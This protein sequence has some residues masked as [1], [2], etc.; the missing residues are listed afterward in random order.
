MTDSYHSIDIPQQLP[1]HPWY[2]NSFVIS[3]T[4]TTREWQRTFPW[5][6][7]HLSAPHLR[8]LFQWY[9][10]V[11][12]LVGLQRKAVG[13]GGKSGEKIIRSEHMEEVEK[14]MPVKQQFIDVISL[15]NLRPARQHHW[16]IPR[17]VG[18]R[19]PSQT[20][21]LLPRRCKHNFGMGSKIDLT[22][23]SPP[24]HPLHLHGFELHKPPPPR[25]PHA[26]KWFFPRRQVIH[27][28]MPSRFLPRRYIIVSRR[29]ANDARIKSLRTDS[30]WKAFL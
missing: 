9:I 15:S 29:A 1:F 22:I 11:E 23:A 6:Q 27:A 21:I 10:R 17:P 2:R 12:L 28:M 4:M 3:Q 25:F 30:Q 16:N 18:S 20:I 14:A 24:T 13:I 26:M 5:H 8:L 19:A 7:R